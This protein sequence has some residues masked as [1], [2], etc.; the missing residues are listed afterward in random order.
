MQT[1]P[2]PSQAECNPGDPE[3][4]FL[5]ALRNM[6]AFAGSGVVTHSGFLRK[7]SR[8]LWEAGFRHRDYLAKLADENGNISISK[9][10]EQQI[11]FQEA[12]RGPQHTYNN[13]AR[14]VKADEPEPEVFSIPD[15]RQMTVQE[16]YAL[17]YML[18][19]EGVVIPDPPQPAKAD[20]FDEKE[21]ADG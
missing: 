8:H 13:A 10:P 21:A 4:H 2:L 14:W 19:Q 11:R 6:P 17:A 18:K 20:V 7:W 9:L 16:K 5:W 1:K 12:F 3:E 15:P